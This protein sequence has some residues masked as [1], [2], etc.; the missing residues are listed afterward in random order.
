M[1]KFLM[2]FAALAFVFQSCEE[3]HDDLWS[4]IDDLDARLTALEAQVEALNDNVEA[5][6]KLYN[7]ATIQ[8]VAKEGDT[9]VLTLSNGEVIRL[10]QGSTA[11][12]VIPVF[13]I[14]AAGEW[15]YSVDNGATWITLEGSRATAEDGL[16]P[17]FRVDGTTGYWQYRYADDEP[18]VNVGD[19]DG[20]PVAAVGEGGTS[21]PFFESVY[22]EGDMLIVV[23]KGENEAGARLEIP[24]LP[25]FLCRIVAEEGVQRFASG[26]SRTFAVEL[27]GVENTIVTAPDGWKAR[28]NATSETAAELVV[29]APGASEAAKTS[30]AAADNGRDVAILA[31]R[32]SFAVIAKIE[33][34]AVDPEAEPTVAVSSS[35]TVAPT[36]AT[37]T[38]DVAAADAEGWKWICRKSEEAA[39]EAAEIMASGTEGE[40]ASV[41]VDGLE[42]LTSYTLY[43]AAYAGSR[44]SAVAAAEQTTA[45]A[46]ADYYRDYLDGKDIQIGSVTFNKTTHPDLECKKLSE[47]N[48]ANASL[49]AG[50]VFFIDNAE[51][52]Q[53]TIEGTSANLARTKDVVLIGRYP[54]RAQATLTVPEMRCNGNVAVKNLHLVATNGTTLFNSTNAEVHTGGAMNPDL[55]LADCTIDLTASR[56]LV[57]DN[58]TK[59]SS[60][61]NILLDNSIVEFK[62]GAT[63]NPA[64]YSITTTKKPSYPMQSITLTNN[65]IYAATAIQAFLI[66]CGDGNN[67]YPTEGLQITVTGNTIYNLYQPNIMIRAYIL[68]GLTVTHN[69]AS[70]AGVTGKKSYLTG[71]Y[72]TANFTADKGNVSYNYLYIP[73][74]DADT[75]W[76]ARHT[77]SYPIS[78][79]RI[80]SATV[81][82]LAA[83]FAAEQP[84]KGYFPVNAGAVTIGAEVPGAVYDTKLWFDAQ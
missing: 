14:N 30:R 18:W 2:F 50:G 24:I 70:Y 5:L 47:W 33:V 8:Q 74:P 40:G 41:T 6:G 9:Y 77:G 55:L 82:D 39:P 63:N 66:N 46:E 61:G 12:A 28:L 1:K 32:G 49:Q 4:A 27:R 34:E 3:N 71:V 81:T 45:E 25:D 65:V 22:V 53:F 29:T 11:D 59:G 51:A 52:E 62:A 48:L 42:A 10:T 69:V 17:Q 35:A 83:P 75:F 84:E 57:Y 13:S 44:T 36:A 21:D 15:Q 73:A 67:K 78:N 54:K 26:E 37:L 7:G 23:M 31:T 60:F 19:A 16:T 68:S 56:Y 79:N 64:I 20:N 58:N 72:D 43:V 76:S 38:F 80:S